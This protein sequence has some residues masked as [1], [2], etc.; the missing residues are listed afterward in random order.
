MEPRSPVAILGLAL[1][2]VFT[3]IGQVL[4][5]QGMLEM[6]ASPSRWPD[7]LVFIAHSLL[8]VKVILGLLSAVAAAL[9]WLVTV[10][11]SPLSFAYPFMGLS[12]I[13]VLLFSSLV[14]GETVPWN[15][16]AGV[17][18]VCLGLA[19]ASFR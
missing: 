9:A 10:S 12:L 19:V 5:K 16:W 13:L 4:T 17:G 1:T 2:V 18:V 15:R 8:N 6:G 14:F 7:V 3:V 11:R